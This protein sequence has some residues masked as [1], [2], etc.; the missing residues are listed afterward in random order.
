M[1]FSMAGEKDAFGFSQDDLRLIELH[2]R[3]A[4]ASE[5]KK[6]RIGEQA[7]LLALKFAS[8][9]TDERTANINLCVKTWQHSERFGFQD[10]GAVISAIMKTDKRLGADLD[11]AMR[12]ARAAA[13][14][15]GKDG[16]LGVED[17]ED[18]TLKEVARARDEDAA[19]E[20]NLQSAIRNRAASTVNLWDALQHRPLAEIEAQIRIWAEELLHDESLGRSSTQNKL[21]AIKALDPELER[22]ISRKLKILRTEQARKKN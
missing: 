11:S 17:T 12:K 13:R 5:G 16:P 6:S 4:R 7:R 19:V 15:E 14:R 9:S 8:L 10:T 21:D 22:L 1:P 18:E 20:A 2:E 3:A